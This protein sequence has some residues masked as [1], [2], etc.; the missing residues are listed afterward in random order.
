MQEDILKHFNNDGHTGF[1]FHTGFILYYIFWRKLTR[2]ILKKR[3]Y[4]IH[5]LTT[6]VPWSLNII[7][8]VWATIYGLTGF[9]GYSMYKDKIYGHIIYLFSA[10]SLFCYWFIY[11]LFL[12]FSFLFHCFYCCYLF[13]LGLLQS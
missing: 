10:S 2:K 6:M 11:Y 3:E 8:N 9:L 4:G 5:T 13:S 7:N 1:S 12:S